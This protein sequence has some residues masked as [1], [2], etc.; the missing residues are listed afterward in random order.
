MF[1]RNSEFHASRRT[2]ILLAGILFATVA[3]SMPAARLGAATAPVKRPDQLVILSTTDVKGKMSPCGCHV[4]K[5]G[6]S[7]RAAFADSLRGDY[8]QMVI[9]DC[10]GWYPEGEDEYM[11]VAAFQAQELARSG[12]DAVGIG[13]RELR[14]GLGFLRAVVAQ[15]HL[16]VVSAN[17]LDRVTHRLVLPA[18]RIVKAGGVTVGVFSLLS[19]HADLGPSRDSLVV[20]EPLSAARAAIVEMQAKGATVIVLLANMGKVDA[21]DLVATV[22]GVDA[23]IAGFNVPL[24]QRGRMVK[25]TVTEFGGEQ[26]HYVGVTH[27]VLGP[28]QHVASGESSTYILG[29]EVPERPEVLARVKAFEDAFNDHQRVRQKERTAAAM[30]ASGEQDESPSHYVGAEVCG[31]CH[32]REYAQ[33]RSTP[34][35]HALQTLASQKKDATPECLACHAAGYGKPGGYA[36]A[37]DAAKMGGVQCESC[38]GIGT[39]HNAMP[40]AHATVGEAVC[41]GCHT[42]N[43][44]P[45]F[46]FEVYRPHVLHERPAV[47]PELPARPNGAGMS[48]G[49]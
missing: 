48:G 36:S 22:D 32:A 20:A 35:A 16:P 13:P 3:A 34:H 31:R 38:H 2:A 39:D 41:R 47:L 25:R 6:F 46:K 29:P 23:L 30:A 15:S 12:A 27:L 42:E 4:P 33:W 45:G 37:D 8:G 43:D 1:K 28:D 11:E 17:L 40:A 14:Y 10:G 5:G 26:G 19:E 44:S 18:Y 9:V 7:R 21:E 49:H 24:L